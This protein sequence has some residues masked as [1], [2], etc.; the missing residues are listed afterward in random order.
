MSTLSKY[1]LITRCIFTV[2]KIKNNYTV[3]NVDIE[4]LVTKSIIEEPCLNIQGQV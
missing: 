2:T 1:R 3:K 4:S